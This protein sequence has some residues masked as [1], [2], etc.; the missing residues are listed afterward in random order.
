MASSRHF[1]VT[2]TPAETRQEI[3][4]DIATARRSQRE[5]QAAG[6]HR[7]A[8]DMGAAVD[9][10]RAELADLDAGRWTPRHR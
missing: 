6:Q 3:E 1:R 8:K 5:L 4:A 7:L 2:Q 9:E 10:Y